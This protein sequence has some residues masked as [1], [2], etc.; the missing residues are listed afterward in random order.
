MLIIIVQESGLDLDSIEEELRLGNEKYYAI[1]G[2][3]SVTK[4]ESD[5]TTEPDRRESNCSN[6][7]DGKGLASVTEDRSVGT[8]SAGLYWRYFRSGLHAV[9]LILLILLFL[10]AQG[11]YRLSLRLV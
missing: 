11:E 7:V 6:P 5:K 8:I 1:H 4:K 10:V 9:L 3:E 2:V